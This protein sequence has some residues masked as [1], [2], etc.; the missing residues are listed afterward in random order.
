MLSDKFKFR[1]GTVCDVPD[2]IRLVEHRIKWMDSNGIDQW[3][4]NHYRERYPD[5]YYIQC[6]ERGQL[7]ILTESDS[8]RVVAGA[9]LLTQDNRWGLSDGK[10]YYVHN[11]VSAIDEGNAGK[12]MLRQIENLTGIHGMSFVRLDCIVGNQKLNS[13]YENLG[14]EYVRTITDGEYQGNLREKQLMTDVGDIIRNLA[15]DCDNFYLY[16]ERWIKRCVSR[17]RGCFPQIKFLYSIKCNNNRHILHSVFSQGLGADAASVQEVL[18]AAECG[19]PRNEIYYSAPGK[20]PKDIISVLDKCI[21]IADSINEIKLIDKIMQERGEVLNI[22]IRLNPDFTFYSETGAPSKFGIDEAEAIDFINRGECRNIRVSGIHVHLRSQELNPSILERYYEKMIDLAEKFSKLCGSLQYVNM[23]SGMGIQYSKINIPLNMPELAASVKC[24]LHEFQT[25]Y[26]DT[27]LMIETGRYA[28]GEC[29][30]YVTTVLDRKTSKGKTFIILKNT[31]N[32][33]IR[34]SLERLIAHYSSAE[35]PAGC[36]PLYSCKNAFD[37]LTLKNDHG[38]TEKV[39]LVGNLCTSSDVVAEDIEMPELMPGDIVIITNAGAYGS[40]L[41][42]MQFSSQ[43]KPDEFFV[44]EDG[45]VL[46]S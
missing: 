6:A 34:P 45:T 46:K 4:K 7:Y 19:L 37:F 27:L 1:K 28:V 5:E 38:K 44:S 33:F 15:T 12:E 35:N 10:A 14:Y 21:V 8:N 43:S 29:G 3:N 39:T 18:L 22:G 17:L 42:P 9:V 41:S 40:V 31:L 16:D 25:A 20:T 23:G 11:L 13:W 2:I 32:G 30:M 36:E 24:K 26:P